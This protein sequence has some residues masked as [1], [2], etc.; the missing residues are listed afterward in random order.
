MIRTNFRA[1]LVAYID[2]RLAELGFD[3]D[4]AGEARETVPQYVMLLIR[5]LRRM[6]AVTP[7]RVVRAAEFSVPDVHEAG[8][9][10]LAN[11]VERGATLR[12]WLSL[13]VA[14]LATHDR[15]LDDWGIHHFHL[16]AAPHPRR[17]GFVERTEEV[18]FAMVHPDAIYFL[19]ATSH[20]HRR[21]PLVW[22]QPLL[23][24][25]VHRNWP[26]LLDTPVSSSNAAGMSAEEHAKFRKC[27][28][29][30]GVATSSGTTYYPPGGGITSNGDSARDYMYQ[31]SV[32][33][34]V[35]HL[36]A[37]VEQSEAQIRTKLAV[38]D[39]G[40]LELKAQFQIEYPEG[41]FVQVYDPVREVALVF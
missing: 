30:V 17:P 38:P 6:P 3:P 11:A 32:L 29:N 2:A 15:L 10:A 35:E 22:T 31:M 21:A 16:G 34:Q 13:R 36:E 5:A 7:R 9:Q 19:V 1:D 14:D 20:D 28:V 40:D 23:V 33:R 41:H 4:S 26:A 12:P 18:A 25:L 39:G 37:L 24:D 8:F 27:H